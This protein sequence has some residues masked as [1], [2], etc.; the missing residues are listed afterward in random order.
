[1]RRLA[2]A[3]THRVDCV[4]AYPRRPGVAARLLRRPRVRRVLR[5]LRVVPGGGW[6]A[7]AGRQSRD[8]APAVAGCH[9]A[10]AVRLVRGPADRTRRRGAHTLLLA[11]AA[12]MASLA[13]VTALLFGAS[14][15]A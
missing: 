13:F 5:G 15:F 7:R 3:A 1:T 2:C 9:G 12:L 6:I 8:R 10:M 11:A 14:M 4:R